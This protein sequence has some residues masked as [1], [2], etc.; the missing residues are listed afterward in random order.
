MKINLVGCTTTPT[1]C[2]CRKPTHDSAG[3]RAGTCASINIPNTGQYVPWVREGG[4]G[5]SS[6]W[7][8]DRCRTWNRHSRYL[9]LQ[10]KQSSAARTSPCTSCG[11]HYYRHWGNR[12]G[13]SIA[14]CCVENPCRVTLFSDWLG[15]DV[16]LS[17]NGRTWRGPAPQCATGRLP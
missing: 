13:K 8:V 17:S 11:D 4:N 2:G 15:W 16:D 6:L 1:H 10:S 14:W 3:D 7:S 9:H 12:C 5:S